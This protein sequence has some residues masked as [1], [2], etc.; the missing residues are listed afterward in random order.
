LALSGHLDRADIGP[1]L[2]EPRLNRYDIPSALGGSN[3]KQREF[4]T[5]IGGAAA[6]PIITYAQQRDGRPRIGVL[7]TVD[8]GPQGHA[9]MAAFL[10][11][12][13]KLGWTDGRNI[14]IDARWSGGND[15][16]MRKEAAELVALA[17]NVILA[18]GSAV[19][20]R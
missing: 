16:K 20:G 1:S 17:P 5:L 18:T 12:L 14:R 2:N 7:M 6:W 13:Q 8:D 4:I 11:G 19:W 3:E 9:R 10:Q 15:A